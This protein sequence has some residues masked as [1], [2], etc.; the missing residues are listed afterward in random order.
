MIKIETEGKI[1]YFDPFEIKEE[2]HDA[3]IIFITHSHFDHYSVKDIEKVSKNDTTVV[4]PEAMN[5]GSI[6][7]FFIEPNNGLR[8][9]DIY[10]ETV[11]SYN[12]NK[13]YHKRENGFLGY[14]LEIENKKVYIMGDCDTNHDNLK[15]KC[16]ILFIPIGGQYTFDYH[17]AIDYCLITKPETIYPIHLNFCENKDEVLRKF[18]KSLEKKFEVI[19]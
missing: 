14:V 4:M 5:D 7:G 1:I 18:K 2:P 16:D 12:L 3:D 8:V 15:V 9:K 19:F 6:E 13:S 11:L 10:F 17:E